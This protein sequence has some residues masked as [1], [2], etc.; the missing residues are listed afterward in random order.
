MFG[1]L[2]KK[3]HAEPV[4][5]P[6]IIF[7]YRQSSHIPRGSKRIK[8]ASH[9]NDAAESGIALYNGHDTSGFTLTAKVFEEAYPRIEIE[10]DAVLIGTIWK[11]SWPEQY[12]WFRTGAIEKVFAKIEGP[13]AYIFA[14]PK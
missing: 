1:I 2:K 6:T 7:D 4:E 14:L 13:D 12:E 8:L 3:S 5:A 9:G 11:D 10:L